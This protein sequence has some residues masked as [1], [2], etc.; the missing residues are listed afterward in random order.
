MKI[1][2]HYADYMS[3]ENE[4]LRKEIER[5]ETRKRKDEILDDLIKESEALKKKR[6]RLLIE[7]EGEA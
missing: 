1:K 3:M 2:I 6:D 5:L 4:K 7:L